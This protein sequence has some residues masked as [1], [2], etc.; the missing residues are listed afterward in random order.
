MRAS[1]CFCRPMTAGSVENAERVVKPWNHQISAFHPSGLWKHAS[2]IN[3]PSRCSGDPSGSGW[4][5]CRDRTLIVTGSIR[6]ML[7]LSAASSVGE[8]ESCDRAGP[9]REQ[10]IESGLRRI[11]PEYRCLFSER[12]QK[13][14]VITTQH[15]KQR[16]SLRCSRCGICKIRTFSGVHSRF[17]GKAAIPLPVKPR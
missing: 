16:T 6:A 4:L 8:S 17:S 11:S 10:S 9:D 13:G 12:S 14:T 2:D 3:R 5:R 7:L 1:V 15:R